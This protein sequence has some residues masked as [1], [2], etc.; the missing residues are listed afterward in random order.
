MPEELRLDPSPTVSEIPLPFM[1]MLDAVLF[2]AVSE[3][4]GVN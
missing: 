2:R 3:V 4:S 1:S